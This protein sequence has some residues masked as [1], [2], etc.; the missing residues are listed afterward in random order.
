MEVVGGAASVITVIDISAKIF[1]LCQTYVSAVK[2]ARK[3]IQ[4]LRDGV[5]SLQD[6]LTDVRD[7]AEDSSLSGRSVFSRLNQYDGPVQQCERDLRRLVAQLE[8]GEG[9][10]KMR[11]F[12]LRA[13]KW[14]FSSKDIDKRLQI[15]NDY[16][17]T[18]TLALTSDN[19]TLTRTIKD[20]IARL[21][22]GE[23]QQKIRHW[24]SSPDPSTNH[25]AACKL[26]QATTGE[27]FLKSDEFEKWKMTSRS[28]LWLY[29]IPGCG[30]SVLCS[31]A[32]EEVKSQYKS[33]Y[34]VEI[35]TVAIAYFYFDFNDS[36]K[37]RHD[38]FTHS[39]IEQ[40]AWQSAKALAYLESLFSHCQDG[41][42][43]PTQDALE[44][45]LQ[46]MLNEFGETFIILDA[47]DE[48][49]E[50]EEL[51]LLLKN[52]TSW[53]AG[54]LHVLATSRRERDIEEALEPLV[55]SEICL[56]SA[57]V[58][59]DI[60]TYLSERLQNDSRLKRWPA[61][62]RGEIK[63]TLIEGAQGMFRWVVCQL[64]VLR[65][66]LKVDALRK[67][68]KSLPKTLDET[69]A[70]I[71]LS[72]NEDY[73]QDAFRILQWLVY[74]ARPLRIEEMV[75]VIAI[76]T[77]Q[78]RFNPENRL[79]DPRD[80]LTIC[81]SL[82]TTISVTA[83]GNDGASNETTELRLAHFSVKE[84]LIS[85][86]I[87]TGTAFQY[88]IQSR[89]EEEIAQSCLTYLLQFQ[90][91]VLTSGNLNTFPLALYAARHWCRH[92]R[93]T[94]DSD[95]A[96]K[97][98]MQLFQGEAFQNWI[99]LY[100]LDGLQRKTIIKRYFDRIS[101]PL[102]YASLE[103]LFE[104]VSLLLEKGADVNAQGGSY[105]NALQAALSRGHEATTALLLEKGADVNAQGGFYGNAL[106]AASA[107]GHEATTALLLEKGANVNAQGGF[108][109]NA[110]QAASAS[111]HEAIAALLIEKGADVNTQGGV[112]GNALQA[113]S[114]EGHEAIAAL[115][116]E[117]GANVNA[118]GR[119][120][121]NALQV[122]SGKGHEAIAALLIE[123]GANVNAQGRYHDNALQVASGKGHE[124]IAVLL[125]EKGANVNA[126]GRYHDNALQ[127]AS[128]GG[129]EVIVAL[130]IEKGADVNAQG[131][132]YSNALQAASFRGR[133]AIAVLLLEKGADVNAQGGEYGNALQAASA[134]GH[135]AIAALLIEKGADVN[136]QA[137][138]H[139]N[140]LQAASLGGHEAIAALLIEKG[141]NVNAQGGYH[142]NALQAASAGGHEA[143]AYHGNA[144]QAA[145]L[146]G[147]EAI[148]A[149]LIEKGANVNAQ[150]GY[151]GNALQAASAR[152]HEAIVV[153][154]IEKGADVNTQS[155]RYGNAL[156]KASLGGHEAIAAL[157][158][159]KGADVNAQGGEYG[160]ALQA[161]SFRGRAA[162]AVLLLE[163][164]ADV[165]AQGGEYGN[166]L[167]AAAVQGHEAIAALLLKEGADVNAQGGYYG[168]AL[169]AASARGHEAI[170]ALLI[171]KGADVNAQGGRYGNALQAASVKGHE[172]VAALLLEKGARAENIA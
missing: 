162:I 143:I 79:P 21:A 109:G 122:A 50:R 52:L 171:E 45:A 115:L 137:G 132:E 97:L 101:S 3:D 13:L 83:E 154:L 9:E 160:N 95:Q 108:Y 116:I 65:K 91:G 47:L 64:E 158:I 73:R 34:T 157:L 71:L 2:E 33:N 28:F 104:L 86:R 8:L 66:C 24:L 165:N 60:R 25:N 146:G 55:T 29:G 151:H 41:K 53:G 145:S 156:Q 161:A 19:F 7:L 118:Q 121:D 163:K 94:K 153:L 27:W 110:L 142:G 81:S 88:D 113:A 35:P 56:Q 131:G 119:Y 84:Y 155:K 58:D 80:L 105:G 98:V 112:Y 150:G 6:V 99:R 106:Q 49:K 30:K 18:F 78:S 152:G 134:R 57:I 46:Q 54:N 63:D 159:E 74:S 103:G 14:P 129:H 12:G 167:Q 147:H 139:G 140:A 42:G 92:F 69:Y 130:L 85:D 93:A 135:E 102:Y 1:E 72:I 114:G 169:Q 38:K 120:H 31:T 125:I 10:S 128:A 90:R 100:N 32:L 48:C 170:A 96:S 82:V 111:S 124:A 51:L 61:N 62:V 20:D 39:L 68:L 148:A 76:D 123:K 168:N 172:A 89:G 26:R 70:R 87:R 138:Y 67:A 17:A 5:T 22:I 36:E 133:A 166:A 59:N 77:E 75:E 11:Q 107:R 144:L 37:Q 149:L 117:K 127:V 16:K 23:K 4:R 40:L 43:Q 141:A 164:G 15:I 44:V 136:A 126:Q